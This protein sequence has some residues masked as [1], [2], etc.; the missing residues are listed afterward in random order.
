MIYRTPSSFGAPQTLR[1]QLPIAWA[2]FNGLSATIRDSRNITSLTRG[3]T[4]TYTVTTD[5][6]LL[7]TEY[8]TFGNSAQTAAAGSGTLHLQGSVQNTAT[9]F[10]VEN[11]LGGAVLADWDVI[12]IAFMGRY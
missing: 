3:T 9:S 5:R 7:A 11:R 4:G 8:I 6:A 2:N 1:H 12:T 10:I